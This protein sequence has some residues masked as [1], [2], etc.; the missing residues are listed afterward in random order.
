[1]YEDRLRA[2][3]ARAL[4]K[5]GVVRAWVVRGEDG[6][7][8]VS[9]CAPTRVSELHEGKVHER[10]IRPED[11]GIAP[12]ALAD[13]AGGDARTNAAAITRILEGKAHPAREAVVLNAAAALVAAGLEAEPR[14]AAARARAALD[15]GKAARVLD[16]WRASARRRAR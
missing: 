6:L 2:I 13:I 1:V 7:D 12:L 8:E 9:P 15:E 5:L 10:T 3:V 16:T 14:D 4:G 11:F